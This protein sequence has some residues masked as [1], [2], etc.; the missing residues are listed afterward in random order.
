MTE[1][2]SLEDLILKIDKF[3]GVNNVGGVIAALNETE[4]ER[5]LNHDHTGVADDTRFVT[6]FG[7][8]LGR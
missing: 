7:D 3:V 8:L 1:F 2:L 4:F 6:W 5:I